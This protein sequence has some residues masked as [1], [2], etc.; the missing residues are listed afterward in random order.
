[1]AGRSTGKCPTCQIEY[2]R[3]KSARRRANNPA[4]R[5]RNTAAWQKTR[6]LARA[7]DAGCTQRHTGN[8]NG[9]LEVHHRTP[10]EHGGQ[11][12]D[13]TNLVTLCRHHHE[14]AEARLFGGAT[15]HPISTTSRET[16][17]ELDEGPSV[18]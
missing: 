17:D 2:E 5:T 13:L 15:S 8:C 12:Y 4:T 10:I 18:G 1:M 16:L 3:E 6:A 14:E 7:R 11:P 9:R